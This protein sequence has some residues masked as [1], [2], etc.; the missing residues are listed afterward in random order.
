M[1][2]NSSVMYFLYLVFLI[3]CIKNKWQL[4]I[5]Y[6][7]REVSL[8]ALKNPFFFFF[9]EA[10]FRSLTVATPLGMLRAK[11][12]VRLKW[13]NTYPCFLHSFAWYCCLFVYLYLLRCC[14]IFCCMI[15]CC[16]YC[17][18]KA[19]LNCHSV[20]HPNNMYAPFSTI[21]GSNHGSPVFIRFR[22]PMVSSPTNSLKS[23]DHFL[24]TVK[25]KPCHLDQRNVHYITS[26][27]A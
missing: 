9:L 4:H 25:D 15:C 16:L 3:F 13:P 19:F 12:R 17:L 20:C 5:T 21:C 24:L 10:L 26:W 14:M 7:K 2:G 8:K 22:Y 23:L 6:P 18:L 27:K 11:F 1:K